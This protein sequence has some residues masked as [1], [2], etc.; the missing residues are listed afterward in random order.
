DWRRTPRQTALA[1][2]LVDGLRFGWPEVARDTAV[3]DDAERWEGLLDR[4]DEA[5]PEP[6][7]P[8]CPP[9]AYRRSSEDLASGQCLVSA[10]TR[11]SA[12]MYPAVFVRQSTYPARRR[13]SRYALSAR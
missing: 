6:T 3:A 12:L 5:Q 9:R 4:P 13:R 2:L 7:P 11:I 8:G 1:E 10:S